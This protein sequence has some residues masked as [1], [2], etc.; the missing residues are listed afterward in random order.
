[1]NSRFDQLR[2]EQQVALEEA[3]NGISA[4]LGE[5]EDRLERSHGLAAEIDRPPVREH[6]R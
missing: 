5:L 3:A 4:H 2:R 1:M 6:L